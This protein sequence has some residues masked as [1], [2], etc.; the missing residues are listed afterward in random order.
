MKKMFVVFVLVFVA[1]ASS[2]QDEQ[3]RGGRGRMASRTPAAREA[4]SGLD[5]VPL[6]DWWRE[7]SISA[8][9]NLSQDQY[10]QLDRIGAEQREEI[11]RLER[12]SS[13]AM[14]DLRLAFDS[15][16]SDIATA[17]NRA[18][19]LRDSLFD[20]QVRMLSDE[21]RVLTASQ[22]QSLQR[23]LQEERSDRRDNFGGR[24]N[25]GRRGGVG[26][27]RGRWPGF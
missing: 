21:R 3:A 5:I 12:D 22:W 20:R 18:R 27:G 10:A 13:T 26:S 23:Q 1:C 2:D 4:S 11:T 15:N 25:G 17:A 8:V 7:P 9:L 6:T 16:G 14:R 24:R 19:E